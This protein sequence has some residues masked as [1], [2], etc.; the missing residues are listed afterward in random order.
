MN[1]FSSIL[2]SIQSGDEFPHGADD[3]QLRD[4]RLRVLREKWR[5]RDFVSKIFVKPAL[6]I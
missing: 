3:A 2:L 4:S 5:H 6:V 1:P